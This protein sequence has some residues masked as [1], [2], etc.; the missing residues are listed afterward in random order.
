MV[1]RTFIPDFVSIEKLKTKYPNYDNL[2]DFGKRLAALIVYKKMRNNTELAEK[3]FEYRKSS[4]E[5][6]DYLQMKKDSNPYKNAISSIRRVIDKHIQ[7]QVNVGM[8]QLKEYCDVFPCSPDYLLGYI[9]FPTKSDSDVCSLLGLNLEVKQ[10]LEHLNQQLIYEHHSHYIEMINFFLSNTETQELL[11]DMYNFFFGNY[12]HTQN[13]EAFIDVYD[14]DNRY[15]SSIPVEEMDAV[16]FGIIMHTLPAVK[17][18]IVKN[19]PK[20]QY[21]G[22]S[23][24]YL[25]PD[26]LQDVLDFIKKEIKCIDDESMI[27]LYANLQKKLERDLECKK[28]MNVPSTPHKITNITKYIQERLFEDISPKASKCNLERKKNG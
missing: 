3:I 25:T 27:P 26:N 23:L 2:S 6:S 10:Q 24:T 22:R 19:N 16:F 20:Y 4:D 21:Y 12:T 18:N 17:D 9:D 7:K 28:Q 11:E 8:E 13:N 14:D 1:F 15:C 5:Y